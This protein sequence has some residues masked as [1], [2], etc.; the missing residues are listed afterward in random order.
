MPYC[1][2]PH[3]QEAAQTIQRCPRPTRPNRPAATATCP[4]LAA[5]DRQ[6]SHQIERNRTQSNGVG[7][8]TVPINTNKRPAKL[9]NAIRAEPTRTALPPPQ[10]VRTS[11][12]KTGNVRTRSNGIERNRTGSNFQSSQSTP[13]K[14]GQN[15]PRLSTQNARSPVKQRKLGRK[16]Q[17][18]K[19][20]PNNYPLAPMVRYVRQRHQAIDVDRTWVAG[21]SE[22]DGKPLIS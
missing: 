13:A 10:R 2:N 6:N 11:S 8:P 22:S 3:Q 15:H 12:H 17:P 14:A 7:L 16:P 19:I 5:Q 20:P 9:S 18:G 21:A 4:N 1:P